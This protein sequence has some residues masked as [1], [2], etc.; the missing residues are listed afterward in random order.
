MHLHNIDTVELQRQDNNREIYEIGL[1]PS[2]K[3]PKRHKPTLQEL[4]FGGQGSA[5]QD[6]AVTS[7]MFSIFLRSKTVAA[8][9]TS[10]ST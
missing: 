6:S 9:P 7:Y 2:N 5:G 8:A 4:E 3:I 1:G 10:I